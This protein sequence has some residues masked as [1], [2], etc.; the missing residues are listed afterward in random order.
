MDIQAKD[1]EMK[2]SYGELLATAFD[3]QRALEYTL[4]THWVNHQ[5]AWKENEKDRLNRL[6]SMFFALGRPE[7]HEQ[8]F[9]KADEIFKKFND[10]RGT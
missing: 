8:I 7:I 10:K 1:F 6:R 5:S 2:F 4:E 3:V 9:S